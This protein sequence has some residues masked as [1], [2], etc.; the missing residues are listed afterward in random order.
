MISYKDARGGTAVPVEHLGVKLLHA[1]FLSP[2]CHVDCWCGPE[3]TSPECLCSREDADTFSFEGLP[4][5]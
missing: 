5:N 3:A 2:R 1:Y 4:C